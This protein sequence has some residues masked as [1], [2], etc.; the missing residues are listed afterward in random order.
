M[1]P[2]ASWDTSG[3]SPAGKILG[4]AQANWGKNGLFWSF[5]GGGKKTEAVVVLDGRVRGM[6]KGGCMGMCIAG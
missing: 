3:Q 2:L 6:C 5:S 4:K 1:P